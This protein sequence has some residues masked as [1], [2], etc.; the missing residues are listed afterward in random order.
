[1]QFVYVPEVFRQEITSTPSRLLC[2]LRKLR[3]LVILL[4]SCDCDPNKLLVPRT[5]S[6]AAPPANGTRV[7][8]FK[9]KKKKKPLCE[10]QAQCALRLLHIHYHMFILPGVYTSNLQLTRL[11]VA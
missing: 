1:M 11:L 2:P 5:E 3:T 10:L 6:G 4:E 8:F 9:K 7:A